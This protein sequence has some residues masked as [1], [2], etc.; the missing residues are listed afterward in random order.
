MQD[1]LI[2]PFHAPQSISPPFVPQSAEL[3][4]VVT[5]AP[6]VVP[7]GVSRAAEVNPKKAMHDLRTEML[8]DFRHVANH[9]RLAYG[10]REWKMAKFGRDPD[11][12]SAAEKASMKLIVEL[13]KRPELSRDQLLTAFHGILRDFVH[14]AYDYHVSVNFTRL[15]QARLGFRVQPASDGRLIIVGIDRSILSKA[16]FPF[17]IGDELTSIDGRPVA[18]LLTELKALDTSSS[19][20]ADVSN[21]A[22][23]LTNRRARVGETLPD[24]PTA[25]VGITRKNGTSTTHDVAWNTKPEKVIFQ[26]LGLSALEVRAEKAGNVGPSMSVERYIDMTEIARADD[27][28][29]GFVIGARKSFVPDLGPIVSREPSTSPFDAYIY[30]SSNGKNIGVIRIPTYSPANPEKN[31]KVFADLIARYEIATDALVIDQTNNPGGYYFY[32]VALLSHLSPYAMKM[33]GHQEAITPK[34]VYDAQVRLETYAGI[35][36]DKSAVKKLGK[37]WVGLPVTYDLVV[38]SRHYNQHIID[39]WNA[40]YKLTS[41]F[42]LEGIDYINPSAKPYTKPQLWELNCNVYSAGDFGADIVQR[43]KRATIFGEQPAGAGGKVVTYQFLNGLGIDSLRLT[44]SIADRGTR[45]PDGTYTD[46]PRR[47]EDPIEN[48]G[49][50]PDVH[51]EVTAADMQ[52]GY[53]G[54]RDAVN[55]QIVKMT[56]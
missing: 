21:A 6:V 48:N 3:A 31:V 42:P 44:S 52:N 24:K 30:R 18:E 20:K 53:T 35:T 56:S 27:A 36:D 9:F 15:A 51:Y 13:T 50:V 14:A 12:A 55:A 4:P 43:N 23:R 5:S 39:E 22:A 32:M 49:V 46:D 7:E 10:P 8:D 26:P 40:G 1:F 37:T 25:L 28:N 29:D 2:T 41:S 47:I 33:P 17:E 45:G 11:R 34:Q 16:A 19:P 38:K 54:Y